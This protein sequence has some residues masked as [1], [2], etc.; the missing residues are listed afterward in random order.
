MAE[1]RFKLKEKVYEKIEKSWKL[2]S[3]GAFAKAKIVD[4]KAAQADEFIPDL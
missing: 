2:D 3:Q 4:K 1:P